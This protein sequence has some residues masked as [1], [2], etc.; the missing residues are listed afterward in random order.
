[1]QDIADSIEKDVSICIE[2][3]VMPPTMIKVRK[4]RR[5]Q[6]KEEGK[7]E[8]KTGAERRDV[9]KPRAIIKEEASLY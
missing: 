9:S 1:M 7:V 4:E 3:K 5:G 2:N 8:K 6:T